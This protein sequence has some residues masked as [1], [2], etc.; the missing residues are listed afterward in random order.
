MASDTRIPVMNFHHVKIKSDIANHVFISLRSP[1]PG[2]P[3]ST[4][5]FMFC[6]LVLLHQ[7]NAHK[8]N[9]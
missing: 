1:R 8:I 3:D 9:S 4:A 7:L 2:A 5:M 6:P